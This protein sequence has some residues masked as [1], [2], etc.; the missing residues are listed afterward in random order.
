M[1]M[2]ESGRTGTRIRG[3]RVVASRENRSG[4]I[5]LALVAVVCLL[6]S[7]C[8]DDD[9][10]TNRGEPKVTTSQRNAASEVR[11]DLEPLMKRFP[12]LGTPTSASWVSGTLRDDRVPGPSTYWID[13]VVQLPPEKVA[14]LVA[15]CGTEN[16]GTQP[17]VDEKLKDLVPQGSWL[18]SPG[19]DKAPR[20]PEQSGTWNVS[21]F[22]SQ[23]SSTIVLSAV[24]RTD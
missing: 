14:A 12:I 9:P 6:I 11:H 19:L 4:G 7:A 20:L 1:E 13:A 8:T 23:A 16:S 3:L 18:T 17:A 15:Q 21:Y 5:L 24:G 2:V 22:I 10:S